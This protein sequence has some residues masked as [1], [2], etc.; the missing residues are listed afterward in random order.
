MKVAP[1]PISVIITVRNDAASLPALLR[2]LENQTL[3]PT[4]VILAVADSHDATMAC[5][6]QWQPKHFSRHILEVG[7]ATRSEGRNQAVVIATEPWL[8]FTD[9]GCIPR[10]HWLEALWQAAQSTPAKVVSGFT[11]GPS[12]LAWH[13]AQLPYVLV[14]RTDIPENPLPATRNMLIHQDVWNTVGPFQPALQFAEDYEWSR[15]LATHHIQPVFAS[16][17][18]VDWIPRA[19]AADF[20]LM[21]LRLT[22]GDI[23]AGTLRW[24]HLTMWLRYVA[25]FLAFLLWWVMFGGVFALAAI[26][27]MWLA[28]VALKAYQF[29]FSHW[30]RYLLIPWLQLLADTA[31]LTGTPMGLVEK[32]T[33]RDNRSR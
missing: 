22:R 16:E 27:I 2:A 5:A 31:V 13:E 24:G 7:S 10:T 33:K 3:A 4:E 17:A 26:I 23:R 19:S 9:A 25:L 32:I 12:R 20:W 21:I 11:W 14:P 15:R 29:S 1:A 30:N 28:Y 8:A 6:R 18:R